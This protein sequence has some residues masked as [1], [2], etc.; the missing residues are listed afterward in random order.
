MLIN[1]DKVAIGPKMGFSGGN[2]QIGAIS[3]A[4]GRFSRCSDIGLLL[5][6]AILTAPQRDHLI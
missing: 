6:V 4:F 3:L 2:S 5:E 1:A